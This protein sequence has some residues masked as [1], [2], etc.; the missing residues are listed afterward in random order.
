MPKKKHHTGIIIAA[1]IVLLLTGIFLDSRFRLVNSKF[2][3]CYSNIP[4]SFDGYRIVQLSDLHMV[5]FGENNKRL[6]NLV[7][8]Q[9]PDIIV[10]TG[11]FL[12]DKT[13]ELNQ[14]EKLRPF[15]IGLAKIAPC[16]FVSGNHE[17]ASG[18]IDNLVELLKEVGINYLRNSAVLLKKGSDSIVL[19]GVEDPNGPKD[20]MKPDELA[21]KIALKYPNK[22]KVLIAHRNDMLKKYPNLPVDTVLCGHSHG[23]IIRLPFFGG[24]FGTEHDFLPKYDAGLFN[25]GTYDMIVSRGLGWEAPMFR[26]LNNPQLVT[27]IL[28]KT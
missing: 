4:E 21:Q 25:E 24:V 8:S 12:D 9:S 14:T 6:L 26:F 18:E 16:Y 22:Y 23:G 20:M 11:D 13:P 17:W 5:Q 7:A 1:V 15:L 2:Q 3:L 27:L 19:E 28:K 10:M